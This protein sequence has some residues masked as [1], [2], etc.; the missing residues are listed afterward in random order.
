MRKQNTVRATAAIV[1]VVMVGLVTSA[2]LL[3]FI[4]GG[5]FY[6]E[7]LETFILNQFA[8]VSTA[9]CRLVPSSGTTECE[10]SIELGGGFADRT[11][12]AELISELGVL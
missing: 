2:C 12:T 8:D 6:T 3:R 10:Y 5:E 7:D 9:Y 11:S 1:S 4:V